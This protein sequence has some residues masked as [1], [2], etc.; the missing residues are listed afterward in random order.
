MTALINNECGFIKYSI[1][2]PS[3]TTLTPYEMSF[4]LGSTAY[5][6]CSQLRDINANYQTYFDQEGTFWFNQIPS[7]RNE[8]IMLDDDIWDKVLIS[9]K[10]ST[11]YES[12]K[13]YI[14]VFGKAQDEGY[15]VGDTTYYTPYG[16][17]YDDNPQS[18]FYVGQNNE[19]RISM[20]F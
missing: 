5:N 17:A 8:Q 15:T 18:P 12:V 7:G 11:D 9:Y 2:E 19:N 1:D 20:L 3:P 16:V 4:G 13:N 10:M 14:E 6:I